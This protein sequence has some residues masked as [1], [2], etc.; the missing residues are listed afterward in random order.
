MSTRRPTL[1]L[2][3]YID[4]L[5]TKEKIKSDVNNHY[6][7]FLYTLY[8]SLYKTINERNKED[9]KYIKTFK[10][11]TFSDNILLATSANLP[12]PQLCFAL[13]D[14]I[15]MAS[16]IQTKAL[17]NGILTRGG[18]TLGNI[19]VN[20]NFVYG[21]GLL[22]AISLEEQVANYPRIVIHD[23]LET[24][25]SDYYNTNKNTKFDVDNI[26][27]IDFYQRSV[28]NEA[29]LT[30]C[31]NKLEELSK[32]KHTNNKIISKLNWLISQ[33]NEYINK[34]FRDEIFKFDVRNFTDET[35]QKFRQISPIP[36][37]H[38]N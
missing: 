34:V 19:F 20:E 21:K 9:F 30:M 17:E 35:K 8:D 26:R 22:E 11:K 10:V 16:N 23:C 27:F 29:V 36:L 28:N 4:F 2:I 33:H 13:G 37:I 25:C 7:E 38:N 12:K 1:H 3:A 14:F 18:I 15:D 5:G 32:Q 31:T 24:K 6:F